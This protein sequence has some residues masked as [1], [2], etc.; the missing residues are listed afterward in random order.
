[1]SG[2]DRRGEDLRNALAGEVPLRRRTVMVC[3]WCPDRAEQTAAARAQGFEVSHGLCAVC[4]ARAKAEVEA[5]RVQ[6][7]RDGV[8]L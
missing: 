8:D 1:M 4:E 7:L 3:G 2:R 6:R 5:A